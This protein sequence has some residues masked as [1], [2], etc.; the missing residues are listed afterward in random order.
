MGAWGSGLYA[1]DTTCDVRDTYI[2]YL[3]EG[4]DNQA[5]YERIL[6]EMRDYINSDDEAPFFW[7]ALAETQWKTGRLMPEVRDT[8]LNWIERGGGLDLWQDNFRKGIGWKKTL[9][10]L[11]QKL[12]SP[13][14]KE[15]VI[16]K[17]K[18]V[19]QNPWNLYDMYAYQ[20]PLDKPDC[21]HLAGKYIV[22]QKMGEGTDYTPGIKMRIQAYDKL[23]DTCPTLSDL[24]G[25]RLLP[26]DSYKRLNNPGGRGAGLELCMSRLFCF[27]RMQEYP[28]SQLFFIGNRPSPFNTVLLR[29]KYDLLDWTRIHIWLPSYYTQWHGVKYE[30]LGNG[31]YRYIDP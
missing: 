5:A 21:A 8:A 19:D 30:D 24:D 4:L 10:K 11:K 13:A 12:E 2:E 1:N 31:I 28:D 27:N 14:P 3:Q 18:V 22:L 17:P 26:F 16:R 9:E 6:E 25:V 15:K 29:D 7:Y 20:F 23:F